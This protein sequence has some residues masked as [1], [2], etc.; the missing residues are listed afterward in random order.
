MEDMECTIRR[1]TAL[2]AAKRVVILI[3]SLSLLSVSLSVCLCLNLISVVS[4]VLLSLRS[5]WT[6]LLKHLAEHP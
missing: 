1:G 3:L 5:R 6:R 4:L 2:L